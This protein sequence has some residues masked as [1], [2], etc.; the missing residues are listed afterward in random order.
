MK[1]FHLKADAG[2]FAEDIDDALKKLSKHF[3]EARE[4]N[5]EDSGFIVAGNISIEPERQEEEKDD[6]YVC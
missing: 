2:F 6:R 4:D 1:A 5:W 3:A